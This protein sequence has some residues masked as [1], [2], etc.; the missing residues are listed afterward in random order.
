MN[1]LNESY[2][3]RSNSHDAGTYHSAISEK[4]K[5]RMRLGQNDRDFSR[6]LNGLQS[7]KEKPTKEEEMRTFFKYSPH[8]GS[9]DT[10][11]DIK[12]E[13][14]FY[15]EVFS[16]GSDRYGQLG[17]GV[18]MASEH[19]YT[20]PRFCSYN[21]TIRQVSC[22]LNHAGFITQSNYVYTMGSNSHG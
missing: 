7:S 21:I 10:L 8:K 4:G 13:N 16:W 3:A 12:T 2:E 19:N 11:I 14:D 20:I 5:D 1:P 17:L 22:G 15:T 9:E 18:D 6:D